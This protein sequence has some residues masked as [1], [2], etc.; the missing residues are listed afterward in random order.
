MTFFCLFKRIWIFATIVYL[1]ILGLTNKLFN[2]YSKKKIQ[3]RKID[4]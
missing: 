1:K 2:L 4:N 3:K